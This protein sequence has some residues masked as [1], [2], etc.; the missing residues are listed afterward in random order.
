MAEI[1]N[2]K[3]TAERIKKAINPPAGGKKETIIL[4]GDADLDGVSSVIILKEAISSLN[5][6]V[7]AVY[8]PDREA[9][10][11]GITETGL[12]FLKKYS[13]ALLIAVDC[14]IGNFKE[15]KLAKEFG[16]EII[17]IDHHEILEKLPQA[18]I[19][20]DPKQK[21]DKY[22]FKDL[23]ATGVIFKLAEIFLENKMTESLRKTF[24]ELVAIATLA[25]MM[26]KEKDNKIFIENGLSYLKESF[27]PGIKAFLEIEPFKDFPNLNQKVSKIISILNIRDVEDRLPAS[28]RLLT[29]SSLEVAKE[30]IEKLLIKSKIRKEKIGEILEEVRKRISKKSE[31]IVFEGDSNFE[32]TLISSVASIICKEYKKPTFLFKKM[33]KESS[34]TVRTPSEID[35]VNLMRKCKEYPLT[36]GGHPR[37]AG[38]RIKN[39]SLEKFKECQI[40]NICGK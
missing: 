17:I 6:R 20:V 3:K 19:I 34:G 32:L 14:G 4:Y 8:F 7:T 28:F 16:F 26:P 35:S 12:N 29:T 27:R 25:D 40:K 18:D 1:K 39:E 36:Y 13:P 22:P 15:V 21:G 11:Y 24:L 37:A 38:F 9:E 31:P 33:E 10:G 30:I 2:L 5:G 23:S